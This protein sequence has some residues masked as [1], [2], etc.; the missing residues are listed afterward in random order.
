MSEREA[1]GVMS[2]RSFKAIDM[3]LRFFARMGDSPELA[4]AHARA[5][6][7][8]EAL[9]LTQIT[10]EE[11]EPWD[12][13][14]EPPTLLL[15]LA[16]YRP[17]QVDSHGCTHGPPLAGVGMVAVDSYRDTYI[18]YCF[19]GLAMEALDLIDAEADALATSQAE[20][21]ASRATYAGPVT[22]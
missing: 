10:S 20:E 8:A 4:E 11:N 14:C 13:D 7:R 21:L 5:E 16:L 19:A 17:E 2:P 3:A 18:R 9:R 15:S 1:A 12:G 6:I 22:S